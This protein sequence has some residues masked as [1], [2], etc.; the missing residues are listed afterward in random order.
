M[1]ALYTLPL[2]VHFSFTVT[3][4]AAFS[5]TD[6]SPL[7][8]PPPKSVY[9]LCDRLIIAILIRTSLSLTDDAATF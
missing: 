7:A 1:K 4:F 3:A 6:C 2:R 5:P 8:P 9:S